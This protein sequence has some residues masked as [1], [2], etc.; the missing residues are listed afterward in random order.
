MGLACFRFHHRGLTGELLFERGTIPVADLPPHM[1]QPVTIY[2]PLTFAHM[3]P[4]SEFDSKFT[5]PS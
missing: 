1:H 4:D 3:Y 5:T 2:V